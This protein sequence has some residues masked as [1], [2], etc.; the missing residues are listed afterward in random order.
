MQ[1]TRASFDY[2]RNN[3][4][5]NKTQTQSSFAYH[6]GDRAWRTEISN[7][8]D[9]IENSNLPLA[10]FIHRQSIKVSQITY[11]PIPSLL[12][13]FPLVCKLTSLKRTSLRHILTATLYIKHQLQ[14]STMYKVFSPL[15]HLAVNVAWL[16]P[17]IHFS[18]H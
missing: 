15:V 1:E 10:R 9:N 8:T 17:D 13:Y 11:L 12:V 7:Y 2:R 3:Q 5:F 16:L 6:N 4:I 14:R 18:P